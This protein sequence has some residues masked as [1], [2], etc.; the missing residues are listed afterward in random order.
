ML[1]F[2]AQKKLHGERRP[3]LRKRASLCQPNINRSER[4]KLSADLKS[5]K[6]SKRTRGGSVLVRHV[7]AVFKS[8]GPWPARIYRRAVFGSIPAF[9]AACACTPLLLYAFMSCWYC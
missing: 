3:M 6:E 8:C 7:C 5:R 9:I 4:E 2:E 1:V